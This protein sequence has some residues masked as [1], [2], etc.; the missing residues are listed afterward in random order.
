MHGYAFAQKNNWHTYDQISAYIRKVTRKRMISCALYVASVQLIL[1]N[2]PIFF[3]PLKGTSEMNFRSIL[4][5]CSVLCQWTACP[6]FVK[7]ANA[8]IEGIYVQENY[9]ANRIELAEKNRCFVSGLT[10]GSGEYSIGENELTI[11]DGYYGE[12]KF[13]INDGEIIDTDGNVWVKREQIVD[14]PW[15]EVSP[16]T[17]SVIDSQTEKPLTEFTYYFTIVDSK[18]EFDPLFVRG[19]PVE[20]NEGKF[21]INAPKSCEISLDFSGGN[22]LQGFATSQSLVLRSDN[23]AREFTISVATGVSVQGKVI[24]AQTKEPVMG[25]YISPLVFAEPNHQSWVKSI[26]S[27]EYRIPNVDKSLGFAIEHPEFKSYRS[28]VGEFDAKKIG[29]GVYEKTVELEPYDSIN[30]T[31]T[32][33]DEAGQP[34][35]HASVYG[36]K[37]PG[38]PTDKDGKIELT[39][40]SQLLFTI[41]KTGF[42]DQMVPLS[43]IAID[44]RVLL[45]KMPRLKITVLG[46]D[47]KPVPRYR[48]GAAAGSRPIG[49]DGITE[50]ENQDGKA[51]VDIDITK[52]YEHEHSVFVGVASPGYVFWDDL[53]LR[54]KG[55]KELTINLETGSSVTGAIKCKKELLNDAKVLIRPVEEQK[56]LEPDGFPPIARFGI[57]MK[58]QLATKEVSIK[59]DA[60]FEIT[61]LL[62]GTYWLVV[63]GPNISPIRKKI[64]VDT[65]G[66]TLDPIELVGRGSISGIAY[67]G[68]QIERNGE[69]ILDPDRKPLVFYPGQVSFGDGIEEI[70]AYWEHLNVIQFRTDENGR[71]QIDNVPVGKVIVSFEHGSIHLR[72]NWDEFATV[73]QNRNTEVRFFDKPD[74]DEDDERNP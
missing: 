22:I 44:S 73:T 9:H 38:M 26:E 29:D 42:V 49:D 34:I 48:V 66:Q 54:W 65:M 52:D 33:I 70:S 41:K 69:Y 55:E 43:D 60:S 31:A 5:C 62:P 50:I 63:Y 4:L 67:S 35:P 37:C 7:Y 40:H 24:N 18:H 2:R 25:A 28:V 12:Y 46:A 23:Q 10:M 17:I 39:G 47:G 61:H 13:T 72:T 56:D 3:Y 64:E 1:I 36:W 27:G 6:T 74:S 71:F 59:S 58:T 16:V 11:T 30:V 21:V 53:L 15:K 19:I 57:S 68:Y 20:S 45:K 32:V 51:E 8:D 14:M